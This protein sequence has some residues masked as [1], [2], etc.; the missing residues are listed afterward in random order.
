MVDP[1]RSPR[2]N[3]PSSA[4]SAPSA[5]AA[6]FTIA[7]REL[8]ELSSRPG[9]LLGGLLGSLL[10]CTALAA[11]LLWMPSPAAA[12]SE[13]VFTVEFIPTT[14]VAA[15]ESEA[16]AEV[17]SE[18]DAPVDE[19][20]EP[21]NE[22]VDDA[23]DEAAAAVSE[24]ATSPSTQV[25]PASK[26]KAKPERQ[27]APDRSPSPAPGADAPPNPFD[28]PGA[29]S[30]LLQQGDPWATAVLRAL[31][32]MQVPAWAGQI[33]ATNPYGFRLRIC[34]DGSVDKV[35]RKASTGDADLD[36][37]LAHELTRLDLPPMPSEMAAAMGS[38]CAVLEYNFAWRASGVS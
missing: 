17:P 22:T 15:G 16:E 8:S 34:K 11:A 9:P 28:D 18:S 12:E 30:E 32:A 5:L 6:P 10:G 4:S 3:R 7:A 29:W 24:A 21:T 20:S 35:L 31:Q 23:P 25:E 38:R 27:P 2:S 37:T 36:A 33:S 14:L 13:E 26:P 1:T 19:V